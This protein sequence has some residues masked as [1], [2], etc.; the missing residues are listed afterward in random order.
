M[1][2]IIKTVKLYLSIIF[3]YRDCSCLQNYTIYMYFLLQMPFFQLSNE[4]W[5]IKQWLVQAILGP[6]KPLQVSE[7][8]AQTTEIGGKGSQAQ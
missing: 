7:I 6:Q 3:L 5:E 8:K 4:D 2:V 1:T